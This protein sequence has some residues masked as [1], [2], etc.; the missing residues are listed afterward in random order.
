MYSPELASR[1]DRIMAQLQSLFDDLSG[2]Q[3][4]GENM[5]HSF[6]ELGLDSLLLTQASTRLQQEFGVKVSFRQLLEDVDSLDA[7]AD[8]LDARLAP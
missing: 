2:V 3:I 8:H 5:Q 7:L 1:R 4:A 6:I